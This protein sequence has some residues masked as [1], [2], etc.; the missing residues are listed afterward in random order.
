MTRAQ[1][2]QFGFGYSNPTYQLTDA[3]GNKYVMR[4]KPPGVSFN[5]SAHQVEREY[6]IIKALRHTDVPVPK[7]YSLCEDT[8]V[9]GTAF[10]IMEFIDGRV[11]HENHI[12]HVTPEHRFEM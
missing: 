1:Y 5:K 2:V 7:T 10:Y 11:I 9:I 6:R 4:K 8:T 3:T 12:P